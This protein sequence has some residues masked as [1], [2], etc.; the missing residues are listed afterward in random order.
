MNKAVLALL[1]GHG[2]KRGRI[3]DT[4]RILVA[5]E[6]HITAEWNG[7][8]LP[9]GAVTVVEA[10]KLRTEPDGENQYPH[11]A[12]AGDHE[13]AELVEEHHQRQDEQERDEVAKHAAPQRVDSRQKIEIH[14]AISPPVPNQ[15]PNPS[16][17][18]C[19]CSNFGQKI[20]CQQSCIMVNR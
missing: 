11:P 5:E 1:I 8:E 16:F 9:A 20:A 4:G 18:G 14:K 15:R 6:F 12:P 13:M 2:G 19:L 17:L 7:G 10:E 3:R